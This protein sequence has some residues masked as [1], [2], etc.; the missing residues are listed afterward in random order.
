[1]NSYILAVAKA[2][3]IYFRTP[4]FYCQT[5]THDSW[6]PPW[7]RRLSDFRRVCDF[8][9][10]SCHPAEICAWV[11]RSSSV[12]SPS[13]P[14]IRR[15]FRMR[16]SISR[17]FR[18]A[19]LRT[20]V[21][22]PAA[23]FFSSHRP[24]CGSSPPSCAATSDPVVC[25]SSVGCDT[26]RRD[27][28]RPLKW[29]CSNRL[30]SRRHPSAWSQFRLNYLPSIRVTDLQPKYSWPIPTKV[31][32]GL[33]GTSVRSENHPAL[34]VST[35]VLPVDALARETSRSFAHPSSNWLRLPG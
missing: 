2:L 4:Y 8:I 14:M 31:P 21:P 25:G 32:P 3:P 24:R 22:V 29:R 28:E 7:G 13:S 5:Y 9:F 27:R 18:V 16:P 6:R 20:S 12:H 33:V 15:G 34:V 17:H 19:G 11:M 1:M 35:I 30:W 26:P 10:S 23:F